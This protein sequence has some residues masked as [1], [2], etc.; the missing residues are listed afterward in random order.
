MVSF[1][2]SG[3]EVEYRRNPFVNQVLSNKYLTWDNEGQF[4][5]VVIPS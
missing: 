2:D 5:I 1:K 3:K 4:I